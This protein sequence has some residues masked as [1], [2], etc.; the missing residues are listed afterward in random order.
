MVGGHADDGQQKPCVV[1]AGG[2]A[3]VGCSVDVDQDRVDPGLVD[4]QRRVG[5]RAQRG[6]QGEPGFLPAL[7]FGRNREEVRGRLVL[8][9]AAVQ[10]GAQAR[11]VGYRRSVLKPD[12]HVADW[13]VTDVGNHSADGDDGLTR[14][15]DH[16]RG[17]LVDA[18]A[19]KRRISGFARS[20]ARRSE[21]G[22][23]PK[24]G[25]DADHSGKAQQAGPAES[26][27]GHGPGP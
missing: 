18:D 4:A 6:R 8:V 10:G 14:R 24:T 3:V 13:A 26:R 21:P 20:R 7:K 12:H 16:V 11:R 27:R 2:G 5:Q 23:H 17:H 9:C 19:D 22:E 15:G 25:H 1:Q